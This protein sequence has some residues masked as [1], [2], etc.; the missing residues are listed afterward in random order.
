MK[1]IPFLSAI[2]L[3]LT[4]LAV[5]AGPAHAEGVGVG[6]QAMLTGPAGISLT[7]DASTFY[8]DGVFGLSAG[9]NTAFGLGAQGWY[10]LHGGGVADLA[11]G[12]GLGVVDNGNDDTEFHLSGGLKIRLFLV[13]NLALSSAVGLS[14]I[15]DDDDGVNDDDDLLVGGQLLS[16]MGIT[17]FF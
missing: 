1:T 5:P 3:M 13:S 9:S 14:F 10:V 15:F 6:A 12:G 8:V 7:Y 2:P 4:L 11:V 16:T 17:Y